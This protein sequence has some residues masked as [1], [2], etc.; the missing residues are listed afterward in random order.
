MNK[1]ELI[2]IAETNYVSPLTRDYLL[3]KDIGISNPS[4]SNYEQIIN[5]SNKRFFL[6]EKRKKLVEALLF[7]YKKDKVELE[8]N[9]KVY[10]NILSLEDENVFTFTTGQQ[11]HIFL[12]PLFFLYKIHSLLR[13]V[14]N[15]NSISVESQVVPVFWMASEDHDLEEINYVKLYGETFKWETQSGNAVG[16]ILCKG[17]DEVIDQL[18]ARADK[19]EENKLIFELFRRHYLESRTLSTATRNLLHELF[20]DEGLI[21]LDPDDSTLKSVFSETALKEINEGVLFENYSKAGKKLK[22]RGYEPRVNAQEINYFWLKNGLRSK[23][24]KSKDQITIQNT[25]EELSISDIAVNISQLSPNVIT[26]PI[27][28]ETVLPNLAYIG[29]SAEIEYWLP[30][31]TAFEKLELPFPALILRDSVINVTDKNL[32]LVENSNM[33][34]LDLF[35]DEQYI[36]EKVSNATSNF[37]DKIEIIQTNTK[38]ILAQM[39]LSGIKSGNIFREIHELEKSLDKLSKMLS[40]EELKLKKQE[41]ILNKIL[42]LKSKLIDQK[43]ERVE[44]WVSNIS[45]YNKINLECSDFKSFIKIQKM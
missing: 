42:K 26:R 10:K 16:R 34:W 32:E 28:Q 15:F 41:V 31:Q 3:S 20:K 37:E 36:I 30:L 1:F 17:L 24:K 27:Y 8:P 40:E 39:K 19:S 29:G 14:K 9:S 35:N 44:F 18:E 38:L 43:Q 13:H 12:G 33:S 21:I 25:N 7:Q 5:S 23:L 2:D 45:K 4:I 11:I 22:S 6:E